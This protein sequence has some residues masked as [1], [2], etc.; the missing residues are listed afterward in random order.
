MAKNIKASK[1]VKAIQSSQTQAT[2][3]ATTSG[4][5][6]MQW[7]PVIG[8]LAITF[9]CFFTAIDNKFVN[10]DDDRNF[11][12]NELITTITK[13]N[14]WTN[15]KAIFSTNVIGNYNPLPIWTFALEKLQFG[16]NNPSAWHLN[17]VLL[18]LICVFLVYRI[19]L[20]MGIGWRGAMITALLFGIH[21]MRVESVA[22]V[23]ERKDVLFGAFYLGAL[24][25]YVKWKQ[26]HKSIRW[27][28][29]I[30]CFILSLFS[31]IQAVSLP[32]SML[33]I[34]YYLD[35]KWSI[36][37]FKRLIIHKIP[38]FLLSLGF[39]VF[40]IYYLSKYGTLSTHVD[41][42]DFNFIQRIFL[43]A[44][45]FIIYIV[46]AAVP[47]RLSPLY[48][49]PSSFPPYF[50]PSIL[51]VPLTIYLLYKMYIQEKKALFFGI[52]FFIV[53]IIFLLQVLGAGQ[54]YLADRFTYIAY[55]GLFFIVGYYADDWFHSKS[56][57]PAYLWS[58][59]AI[60][61]V[62]LGS[63]TFQQNKV[64][65]NSGTLWTHVLKYYK[66]TTLPYGNRANYYREQKMYNEALADYEASLRLKEHQPQV[67]NSRGRMYFEA[68]KGRDTLLLALND[69]TK[70][71][72]YL[73]EDGE[74]RINRGATYARLG[75]TQKAIDD[76]SEGLK[77]KPD[78]AVGY[79]NRSI[80]YHNTG[81]IDLALK[82]IESYLQLNPSSGD[83]W[84]EKGRALNLLKRPDE[85][86]L[87]YSE[88]FRH[89]VSNPGLIFYERSK[90]YYILNKI[91]EAK[92]DL[93][94]AMEYQFN[95]IDDNYKKRLGM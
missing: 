29:I 91:N 63:M 49:Y 34:D 33:A 84:Y 19:V 13:D 83:L 73:P 72:E 28:W 14:F 39:G 16:L 21:P 56:V 32:L 2:K 58:V 5:A 36:Q 81:Q 55:F 46:K 30:A 76:I 26:D 79:L 61:F 7:L 9:I 43:G 45:S 87:A 57:Q 51:I 90:T 94:K 50:Y 88:A 69:Y 53:N 75:E 80:M 48:P 12:E 3:P 54:G 11:Y 15:T 95:A 68:A 89:P 20:L 23:T 4:N 40:G 52:T 86:I 31:K 60:A 64:W 24:L 71:I 35:K 65:S 92:A 82:D 78:H 42:T 1:T 6:I 27:F 10:W 74:F 70:A 41:T 62:L 47:F 8:V 17:N 77:L 66:N 22:W 18:H 37:D 44:Y 93:Q 59:S 85:A 25:Q 67:Y 38:V